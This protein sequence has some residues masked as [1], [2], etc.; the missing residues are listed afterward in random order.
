MRVKARLHDATEIKV[1]AERKA[2]QLLD[3]TKKN[4]QRQSGHGDQKSGSQNATPTLA[5]LGVSK[6]QSSR[7]QK[8]A[9]MPEE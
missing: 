9:S 5:E 3:D 7:W 8:L 4:K 6:D 1:R 2:G